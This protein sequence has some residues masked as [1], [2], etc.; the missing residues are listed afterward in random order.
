MDVLNGWGHHCAARGEGWRPVGRAVSVETC[1]LA[2]MFVSC[3]FGLNIPIAPFCTATVF[4]WRDL[5]VRFA[6]RLV[7][8]SIAN[9]L[10]VC[11]Q[12]EGEAE[13]TPGYI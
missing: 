6:L 5:V 7:T 9:C 2:S 1:I 8:H 13:N 12:L 3:S 11:W 10:Y 4:S